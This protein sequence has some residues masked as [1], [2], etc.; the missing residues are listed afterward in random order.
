MNSVAFKIKQF[1]LATM[2]DKASGA[3]GS[4]SDLE[5]LRSF[6]ITGEGDHLRCAAT[7]TDL[8]VLARASAVEVIGE[9]SLCVNAQKLIQITRQLSDDDVITIK[10]DGKHVLVSTQAVKWS[11]VAEDPDAYPPIPDPASAKFEMVDTKEF[12]RALSKVSC[13]CAVVS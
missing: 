1:T 10:R 4:K 13:A 2:L 5:I 12:M 11:L 3:L 6:K 7:D 8:T 9:G